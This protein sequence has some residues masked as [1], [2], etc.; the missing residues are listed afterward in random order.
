ME[1]D[2]FRKPAG[3]IDG[4][5]RLLIGRISLRKATR[6]CTICR[7]KDLELRHGTPAMFGAFVPRTLIVDVVLAH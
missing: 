4:P 2:H 6:P 5:D 1:S 3:A 7:N